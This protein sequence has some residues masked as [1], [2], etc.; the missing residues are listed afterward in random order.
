MSRGVAL[1]TILRCQETAVVAPTDITSKRRFA[2]LPAQELRGALL[3][4]R[5]R[6]PPDLPS[7]WD[8]CS[9]KFSVR[10]ALLECKKV[11]SSSHVP[12]RFETS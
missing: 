1:R 10:H 2:E 8:G 9:H 7:F 4:R 11:V 3:M 12:I 5:A 6:G